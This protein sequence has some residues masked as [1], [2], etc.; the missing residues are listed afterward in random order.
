MQVGDSFMMETTAIGWHQWVAISNPIQNGT[1]KILIVSITTKRDS[2]YEDHSCVLDA[3][4]HPNLEHESWVY[5][6]RAMIRPIDFL[7]EATRPLDP[8]GA[9]VIARILAGVETTDRIPLK[10]QEL[11]SEQGLIAQQL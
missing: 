5:Y 7:A 8:M 11:L 1:E 9:D 10:H 3:E 6:D 4:D 2:S